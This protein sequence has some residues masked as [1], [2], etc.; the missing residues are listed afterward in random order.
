[1]AISGYI[2]PCSTDAKKSVALSKL[3]KAH[4]RA[5][6]AREGEAKGNIRDAF[7]WWKQVFAD[8]FPA[9]D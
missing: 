7:Y 6:K 1:M 4:V 9:Y 5:E 8:K 2:Y 3:V